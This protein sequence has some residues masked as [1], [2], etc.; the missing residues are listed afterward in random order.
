MCEEKASSVLHIPVTI[1]P[2]F[3][4]SRLS[5]QSPFDHDFYQVHQ[6]IEL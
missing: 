5:T 6:V 1:Y 4:T 2:K 3:E